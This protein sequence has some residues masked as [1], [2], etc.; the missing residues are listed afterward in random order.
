MGKRVWLS[1]KLVAGILLTSLLSSIAHTMF[2]TSLEFTLPYILPW[3]AFI[4]SLVIAV[5]FYKGQK[6][7][8][9]LFAAMVMLFSGAFLAVWG[10]RNRHSETALHFRG[11]F[12]LGCVFAGCA[13]FQAFLLLVLFVLDY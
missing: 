2:C 12:L 10:F 5:D 11:S 1:G 6:R 9:V 8:T 3:L 4:S 13:L 7:F